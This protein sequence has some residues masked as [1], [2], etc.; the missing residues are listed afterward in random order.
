[1]ECHVSPIAA[2][3]QWLRITRIFTNSRHTAL[4]SFLL[5]PRKKNNQTA[6]PLL[7]RVAYSFPSDINELPTPSG[8]RI[9][10]WRKTAR[11]RVKGK[12]LQKQQQHHAHK[13]ARPRLRVLAAF[14]YHQ[15][16][17][18]P[19]G[20]T[21]CPEP[22]SRQQPR[23]TLRDTIQILSMRLSDDAEESR[24]CDW[25][26]L[27]RCANAPSERIPVETWRVLTLQ[28]S[29]FG[30]LGWELMRVLRNR[31]SEFLQTFNKLLPIKIWF[32]WLSVLSLY[33]IM[34]IMRNCGISSNSC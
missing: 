7:T 14:L 12:R 33:Y 27:K 23:W 1:M 15:T 29:S 13:P 20:T 22:P 25:S 30:K 8:G 21:W 18:I 24:G 28:T 2:C 17:L 16:I 31:R 4:Y 26:Y 11:A 9:W 3:S 34:N 6:A 19:V 5:F 10:W 32:Y